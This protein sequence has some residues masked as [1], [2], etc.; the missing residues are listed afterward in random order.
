MLIAPQL[1]TKG[2]AEVEA[3]KRGASR[4]GGDGGFD[5]GGDLTKDETMF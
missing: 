1:W 3:E 5:H 2:F 4:Y